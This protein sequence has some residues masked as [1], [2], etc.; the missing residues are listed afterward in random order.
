MKI[1]FQQYLG[2]SADYGFYR[3]WIADY[4]YRKY[5]TKN[6]I[7]PNKYELLTEKYSF[8]FARGILNVGMYGTFGNIS[9]NM[10]C[11]NTIVQ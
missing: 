2:L 1:Y 8:K 3:G 9:F 11:R 5:D 7:K 6:P 4:N 10:S